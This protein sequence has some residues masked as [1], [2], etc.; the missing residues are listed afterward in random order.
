[1]DETRTDLLMRVEG[2]TCDGC[3]AAVTR[4]V[5]RIDPAADVQVDRDAGRVAIRTG[6][7]ALTL[8]EALTKA[9]YTATAMTG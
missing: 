1:M 5:K 9:G 3:A 8:A 4:T 6:A 7:Q 2:M